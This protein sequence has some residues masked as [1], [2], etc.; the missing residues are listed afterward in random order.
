MGWNHQLET[1][2]FS[3]YVGGEDLLIDSFMIVFF[4]VAFGMVMF[5][6]C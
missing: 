6:L 2:S 4:P 3:I 5:F 1:V